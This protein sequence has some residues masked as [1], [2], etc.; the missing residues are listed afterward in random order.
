MTRNIISSLYCLPVCTSTPEKHHQ[1]TYSVVAA[2]IVAS[3]I[4]YSIFLSKND[5]YKLPKSL[6]ENEQVNIRRAGPTPDAD[7]TGDIN[8]PICTYEY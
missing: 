3:E 5:V 8:T 4:D 1:Y 6:A 2:V 7:Q